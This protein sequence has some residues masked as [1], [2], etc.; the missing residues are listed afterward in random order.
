M[1]YVAAAL[2]AT[3]TFVG[4]VYLLTLVEVAAQGPLDWKALPLFPSIGRWNGGWSS[5]AAIA[6]YWLVLNWRTKANATKQRKT[7]AAR[8]RA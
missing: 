7:L 2:A 1:K 4:M 3:V 5:V 6:A 8:A